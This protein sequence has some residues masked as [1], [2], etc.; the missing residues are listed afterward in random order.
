MADRLTFRREWIRGNRIDGGG[1]GQVYAAKSLEGEEAV[2][3]LVPKAPGASR[4]LLFV[5]LGSA[6]NVVPVL[7]SGE[8]A[9]CWAIVMPRAEK[10]LRGHLT[11]IGAP[12]QSLDA[13][14]ILKDIGIALADLNGKIVHRDLKPENVL[15]LDG[16]WCLADFGI[17]RYAEATTA[18]DT[19]KYAWSAPYAAPERWRAER[20]TSATDIYSLGVIAFELLAGTRPF[21]GPESHDFR[22]QQLHADPPALTAGPPALRALVGECL[23]KAAGARPSAANVVARLDRMGENSRAGGLS[24]LEQVNLAEVAKRAESARANSAIQSE[25]E[26]R[27]ELAK[28]AATSLKR[29]EEALFDAITEAAPTTISSHPPRRGRVLSLGRAHLEFVPAVETSQNPWQWR[30]APAF[31]VISQS[32]LVLSFPPDKYGYQGRS[33]SLWF[34]NMLEKGCYQWL[35]TAFM[36]S[37]L[38]HKTSNTNP[39]ALDAGPVAAKALSSA[40]TEYQLAWPFEPVDIADIDEFIDRWASWFAD[41]AQGL[42]RQPSRMPERDTPRIW[43]QT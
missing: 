7:D 33:H 16:H 41:A 32:G 4:E 42:L 30:D 18:P 29:I 28:A 14:A 12:L 40:M 31:D 19:Q 17:S 3:K 6:R 15:L 21:V 35:E 23:F 8:T 25:T 24:N 43:Q 39:F 34:C 1:F 37:P 11:H 13:I 5:D 2:V 26:R 9:D 22:E 20:A 10:S 38:V 27:A 36:I